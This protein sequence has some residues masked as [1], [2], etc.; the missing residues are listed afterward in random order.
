MSQLSHKDEV[1]IKSLRNTFRALCNNFPD[2]NLSVTYS[3]GFSEIHFRDEE[4]R[5]HTIPLAMVADSTRQVYE[6]IFAVK[7]FT[8]RF[9]D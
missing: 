2:L 8:R 4:G 3:E 1:S 9:D 7:T 6:A 5:A